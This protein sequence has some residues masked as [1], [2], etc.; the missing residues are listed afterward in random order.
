M[1][2]KPIEVID[3]NDHRAWYTD[4]SGEVKSIPLEYIEQLDGTKAEPYLREYKSAAEFT[5]DSRTG[6]ETIGKDLLNNPEKF[7]ELGREIDEAD[8]VDIDPDH[9]RNLFNALGVIS[10]LF[11]EALPQISVH[12]NKAYQET[13]GVIEINPSENKA[14]LFIGIGPNSGNKSANIFSC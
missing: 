11:R 4:G 2:G 14:D 7:M 8:S 13:G 12:L 10:S 5:L 9:R 1:Y 6:F 3:Y